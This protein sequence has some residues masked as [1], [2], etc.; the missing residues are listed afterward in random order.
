MGYKRHLLN[1]SSIVIGNWGARIIALLT[2]PYA[3]RTLGPDGIGTCSLVNAIAEFVAAF[4]AFGYPT[5]AAR[6]Y[7]RLENVSVLFNPMRSLQLV[8]SV[9]GTFALVAVA[10]ISGKGSTFTALAALAGLTLIIAS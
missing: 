9:L 5:Y 7:A 1:F 2:V 3:A 6:E 4:V 10:L 8:L